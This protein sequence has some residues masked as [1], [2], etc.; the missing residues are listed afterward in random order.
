MWHTLETP[1]AEEKK[2]YLNKTWR[3]TLGEKLAHALGAFGTTLGT[4]KK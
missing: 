2:K 1:L 4:G 3:S